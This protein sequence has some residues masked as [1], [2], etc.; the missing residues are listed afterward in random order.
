MLILWRR[1][2]DKAAIG[3]DQAKRPHEVVV[4]ILIFSGSVEF[5]CA[6]SCTQ[7]A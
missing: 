2:V 1:A 3:I 4:K 6:Q 7:G 5:D